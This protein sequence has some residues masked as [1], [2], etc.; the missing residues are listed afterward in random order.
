M[1]T[2]NS[3]N[4]LMHKENLRWVLF[5]DLISLSILTAMLGVGFESTSTLTVAIKM[6]Q[7]IR[8]EGKST[9]CFPDT[10]RREGSRAFFRFLNFDL[11]F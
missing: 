5:Q 6:L 1:I 4:V 11:T 3:Y 2:I 7:V 10:I 8:L 9:D